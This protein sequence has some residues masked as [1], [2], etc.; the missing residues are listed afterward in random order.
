MQKLN[1]VFT[2]VLVVGG[3]L[4]G[5]GAEAAGGKLDLLP[6]LQ[7]SGEYDDNVL[8]ERENEIDDYLLRV[9]PA[10]KLDYKTEL[11]SLRGGVTLDVLRYDDETDLNTENQRYEIEG[12]HRA[13]ERITLSGDFSY[14]RDTTLES[15]LEETGLVNVRQDRDR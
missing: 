3:V 2:M 15:E 5:T 11:S 7:I 4:I 13:G 1:F 8:F 10:V 6:T 9:S 14:I 12:S